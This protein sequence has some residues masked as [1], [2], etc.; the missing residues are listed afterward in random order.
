MFFKFNRKSD[1][2]SDVQMFRCCLNSIKK[3]KPSQMEAN[4]GFSST[5]LEKS[6]LNRTKNFTK[7]V[8]K[9]NDKATEKGNVHPLI[10]KT[11]TEYSSKLFSNNMRS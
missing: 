7:K 6:G 4:S 8:T 9:D 11:P 10:F 3:V 5:P 1:T 2:S